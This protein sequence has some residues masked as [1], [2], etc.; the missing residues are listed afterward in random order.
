MVVM[1]VVVM[2]PQRAAGEGAGV[3]AQ[4]TESG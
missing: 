3:L 1:G 2:S 4:L